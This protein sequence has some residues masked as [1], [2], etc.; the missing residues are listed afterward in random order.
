MKQSNPERGGKGQHRGKEKRKGAKGK[1]RRGKKS[2]R[3]YEKDKCLNVEMS[4][5]RPALSS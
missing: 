5:A 4:T 2:K 3:V 1:S